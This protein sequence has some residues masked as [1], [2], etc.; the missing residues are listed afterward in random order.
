MSSVSEESQVFVAE[1]NR[2][3]D[4]IAGLRTEP[5]RT[6][7]QTDGQTDRQTGDVRHPSPSEDLLVCLP[8]CLTTAVQDVLSTMYS[9]GPLDRRTLVCLS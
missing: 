9:S 1:R 5:W 7:R 4:D 3:V 6:L 8:H 2:H